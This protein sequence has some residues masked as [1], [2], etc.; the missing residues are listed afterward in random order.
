MSQKLK[1]TIKNLQKK[2]PVNPT[3]IKKAIHNALDREGAKLS[4]EITVC[5]IT[6]KEI[7]K[8]NAKYLRHRFPT[9]VI[10]FNISDDPKNLLADIAVSADTA[11]RNAKIY[12]TTP[13]RELSLYVIHAVLHLLGYDD[14]TLKQIALMRKKESEYA[15]P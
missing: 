14:Q 3:R 15:H 12:K 6:D 13:E 7:E 5:F 4:G 1:I 9:D 8:L 2:I 11:V 10:S